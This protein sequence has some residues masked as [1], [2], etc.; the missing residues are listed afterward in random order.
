VASHHAY[1]RQPTACHML[2]YCHTTCS[3]QVYNLTT[4]PN[5][6]GF[7]EELNVDTEPSDMSFSLSM[8]QGGWHLVAHS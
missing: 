7:L 5:L 8:D 2:P 6:V 3:T 1:N 4:Y